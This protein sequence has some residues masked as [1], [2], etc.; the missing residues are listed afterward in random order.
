MRH[1]TG[2]TLRKKYSLSFKKNFGFSQLFNRSKTSCSSPSTT[3]RSVFCSLK[4]SYNFYTSMGVKMHV[5]RLLNFPPKNSLESLESQK[6]YTI[7][8]G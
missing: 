1:W 8:S 2:Q 3:D 6:L 5:L 4:D 7:C